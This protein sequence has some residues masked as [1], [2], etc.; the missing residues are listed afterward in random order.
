MKKNKKWRFNGLMLILIPL[1]LAAILLFIASIFMVTIEYPWEKG[2]RW[3]CEEPHFTLSYSRNSHNMLVSEEVL[4]WDGKE[5]PVFIGMQQHSYDVYPQ[6]SNRYDDRLLSGTWK[7]RDG[8]LVLC[9]EEDFI[10]DNQ[11]RELIFHPA[12]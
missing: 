10:F 1:L 7:F 4:V 8:N 6:S 3:V 9:I 11:Y 2:A 12:A 5:I